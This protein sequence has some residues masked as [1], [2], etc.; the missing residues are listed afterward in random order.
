MIDLWMN[1]HYQIIKT[2]RKFI[3]AGLLF[4]G[5]IQWGWAISGEDAMVQRA[6]TVGNKRQCADYVGYAAK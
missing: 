4:L 5:S 3:L 2:M 6:G 1:I